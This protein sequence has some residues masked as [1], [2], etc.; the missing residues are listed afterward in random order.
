MSSLFFKTKPYSV[1]KK[2][3]FLKLIHFKIYFLDQIIYFTEFNMYIEYI[4]MHVKLKI[5][6]KDY[7]ILC[8]L[9]DELEQGNK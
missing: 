2:K 3:R 7:T 1:K 9:R 4:F 5:N 6:K 8:L